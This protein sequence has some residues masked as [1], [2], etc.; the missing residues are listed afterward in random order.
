M[1]FA[2]LASG[3]SRI[4]TIGPAPPKGSSRRCQSETAARKAEPLTG[5]GPSSNACQVKVGLGADPADAAGPESDARELAFAFNTGLARFR[6]I[7]C[8]AQMHD[9]L[10]RQ[11]RERHRREHHELTQLAKG[12]GH[13]QE[14]KAT[15]SARPWPCLAA[16][17]PSLP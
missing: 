7:H 17:Y 16:R 5:S 11:P 12:D 15:R 3:G 13:D 8:G 9:P 14:G 2:R 10:A 4:R 1:K 6:W